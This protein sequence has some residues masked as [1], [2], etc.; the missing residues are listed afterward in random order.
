[1]PN[2]QFSIE[3]QQK[4]DF[5]ATGNDEV[6]FLFSANKGTQPEEI[7]KVASGGELSRLMLAIKT[8]V[9]RSKALPAIIFDEIDSGISG[10]I[11]SKMA[12]ILLSMSHYM[13]VINIT[14]LPQIA[15]K[16]NS[17]Y[18]V[19][20]NELQERVETG[21]R[22]L[23]HEERILEIAKMLSS[24]KPT[25]EAVANARSLLKAN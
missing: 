9:A 21:M 18:L 11:A 25:P 16:G 12:D 6:Y 23:E 20:K 2:A 17:H 5:S 3:M 24:E 15:S 13:Q 1:M 10:E 19:Y 14:H 7:N 8:V 4:Q 22:I